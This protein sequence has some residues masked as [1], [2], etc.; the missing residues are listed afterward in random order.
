MSQFSGRFV[1]CCAAIVLAA[2]VSGCGG[3]AGGG[4][5]TLST[6]STGTTTSGSTTT[7]PNGTVT[8]TTLFPQSTVF[9]GVGLAQNLW[10]PDKSAATVTGQSVSRIDTITYPDLYA[11]FSGIDTRIGS[12][13]LAANQAEQFEGDYRPTTG[14]STTITKLSTASAQY[15]PPGEMYMSRQAGLTTLTNAYYGIYDVPQRVDYGTGSKPGMTIGAFYS[16]NDPTPYTALPQNVTATYKGSFVGAM[17]QNGDDLS[18]RK[19]LTGTSTL[20]AD[21]GANTINGRIDNINWKNYGDLNKAGSG[22]AAGFDITMSGTISNSLAT[23]PKTID[24]QSLSTLNQNSTYVG[25]AGV[26]QAGTNTAAATVTSSK[27]VGEFYGAGAATTLGS[28]TVMT[29]T[30]PLTGANKA[31]Y[32]YGAYGAKK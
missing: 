1:L 10:M 20:T 31:T 11:P 30:N 12:G 3:G 2:V 29:S 9:G 17:G 18:Q 4:G 23:S 7:G 25:T 22:T 19:G 8:G 13:G 21:F 14:T 24:N 28:V 16:A 15:S 5:A 27:V 32:I 6:G 26:V